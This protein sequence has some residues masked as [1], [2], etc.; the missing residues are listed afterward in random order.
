MLKVINQGGSDMVLHMKDKTTVHIGRYDEVIIDQKY[1]S[2]VAAHQ[3]HGAQIRYFVEDPKKYP[4]Q[5]IPKEPKAEG[6]ESGTKKQ[7]KQTDN[8]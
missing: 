1:E 2:E 7:G 3:S 6:S 8:K 4:K 5:Q